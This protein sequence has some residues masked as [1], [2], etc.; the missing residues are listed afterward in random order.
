[1]GS[2]MPMMQGMMQMMDACAQMMAGTS[3]PLPQSDK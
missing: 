1:M 2:M 3:S